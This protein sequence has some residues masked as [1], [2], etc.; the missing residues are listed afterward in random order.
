MKVLFFINVIPP[1]YGGGFLRVFRTAARFKKN[2]HLF[3]ILTYTSSNTFQPSFG[4]DNEDVVHLPTPFVSQ[5]F[6]L[7]YLFKH[8]KEFDA[9]YVASIHWFTVVPVFICHL[10][11]KQVAVGVTLSG[12]D[13]PANQGLKIKRPYF[14]YKNL[15]FRW[16]D[17]VLVNSKLL[18]NE[19]NRAGIEHSKIKLI[20]NPVDTNK[21]F[22][23]DK[24]EKDYYKQKIGLSSTKHIFLF[25][26]TICYR[27]GVDIF[28]EIFLKYF[29]KGGK[30]C[31]FIM[32][33]N[34]DGVESEVLISNINTILKKF[35]SE[36]I[37][38]ENVTNVEDY[39]KV[40][41]IFLFPTTNEGMPNV[42]LEA[43]ASGCN[44]ICNT[45][46]GITDTIL[47]NSFLVTNNNTDEYSDKMLNMCGTDRNTQEVVNKHL[48]IIRKEFIPDIIDKQ[49][50][51]CLEKKLS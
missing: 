32:C 40:A 42:V 28:P 18:Q 26:G 12:V 5:F 22:P 17:S 16:A 1:D 9:L 4:I 15:Q 11:K 6:F 3:K 50:I 25:V 41:D 19:C 39:Y 31:C 51:E 10:L 36:L 46:N 7:K 13:S 14:Y 20:N 37:V 44:I 2:S 33:G 48:C 38:R 43:M 23:I 49:I 8:K 24:N 27:K 30:P 34:K 47:D 45:L 29:H 35:D 21:F